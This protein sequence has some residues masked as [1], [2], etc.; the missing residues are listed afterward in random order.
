MFQNTYAQIEPET[1]KLSVSDF[2]RLRILI[3]VRT[4]GILA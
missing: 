1:L 2:W 4:Y 3:R